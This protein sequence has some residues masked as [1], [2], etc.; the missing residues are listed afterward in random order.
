MKQHKDEAQY[1]NEKG[2]SVQH[3]LIKMINKILTAL[4]TNSIHEVYAVLVNLVDWSSAFDRQ[5]LKLAI[6]SFPE[7]GVRNSLIPVLK[8][9]FQN[10][11]MFVKWHGLLSSERDLPGGGPQGS[12]LGIQSYLS[13]ST[14][15]ASF[16][17]TDERYKYIDDLS[18]LEIVNLVTIGICSYNFRHHVPSDIGCLL[19]TSPSP[20]D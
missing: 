18:L 8:S 10:R 3:Y 13:Q 14:N 9:F 19:Y 12:S 15:S 1:G 5:C 7:N 6:K 20:R 11:K 2:L 16:V 17:Q 4:D